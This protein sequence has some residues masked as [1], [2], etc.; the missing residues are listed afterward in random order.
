LPKNDRERIIPLSD[1]AIQAV[2]RNIDKHPPEPCTL[3]WEKPNG[4][5]RTC[6]ILFRWHTDGQ[7]VKSRNYSE[8]IWKPARSKLA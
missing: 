2:Q 1:W 7:H 6:N 4:K 5:P 3:P 8:T